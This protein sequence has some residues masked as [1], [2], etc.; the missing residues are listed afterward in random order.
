MNAKEVIQVLKPLEGYCVTVTIG[1]KT[2]VQNCAYVERLPP[3][4]RRKDQGNVILSSDYIDHEG[5]P[6]GFT[7]WARDIKSVDWCGDHVE[8]VYGRNDVFIVRVGKLWQTQPSTD[9]RPATPKRSKT[10]GTR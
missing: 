6:Q 7:F 4:Q 9:S 5:Y 8:I 10:T 1:P 3:S 2:Y